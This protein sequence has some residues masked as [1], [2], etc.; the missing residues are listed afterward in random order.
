MFDE[1]DDADDFKRYG[2]FVL[3]VIYALA[4][5]LAFY[6]WLS[7]YGR[8]IGV[9][10]SVVLTLAAF[11]IY[12]WIKVWLNAR[13]QERGPEDDGAPIT[14]NLSSS[15]PRDKDDEWE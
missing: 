15:A 12:Q 7:E 6:A 1:F 3:P 14:L 5:L 11:A 9:I 13:R 10:G 4:L 2:K 8:L